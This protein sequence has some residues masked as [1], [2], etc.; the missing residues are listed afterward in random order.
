MDAAGVDAP[1][2]DAN[3]L[4]GHVLS[5]GPAQIPINQ[6]R[7]LT[8]DQLDRF[9]ELVQRREAR[10]PVAYIVG[11]KPFAD[12]VI[13][14]T[15]DVLVPRPETETLVDATVGAAR[16]LRPRRLVD[17]GTGSGAVAMAVA[18]VL[19]DV[20]VIASDVSGRALAVAQRN[21]DAWDVGAQV[22]LV[23]ADAVHAFDLSQAVVA[24]NLPYIPAGTLRALEPEVSRWEPREALDGGP[25]GLDVI[26]RLLRQVVHTPPLALLLEIGH[27]Q[28]PRVSALAA[29]AGLA[30][31][32]VHPDLAGWPRVLE[33]RPVGTHEAVARLAPVAA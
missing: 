33:L 15:P 26:R 31:H 29:S 4:L 21:L 30:C 9:E 13:H 10:E 14:V 22:Q 17:V 2:L 8:P 7:R 23:R 5:T 1:L 18:K 25:D 6:E 20:T 28:R 12:G 27:D 11:H 32:A 3:V 19:P 24:A 16:E